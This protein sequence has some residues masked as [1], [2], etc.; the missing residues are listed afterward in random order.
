[1]RLNVFIAQAS[2]LSRRAADRAIEAGRVSINGAPPTLGQQVALADVVLLD[3]QKLQLQQQ[4]Q[5]VLFHKPVGYVCSRNG[6]GSRTIYELLPKELTILNPIGRLDKDSSGLLLLTNDGQLTQQLSHPR[7]QKIK[8]YH[9]ELDS[10]LQPLHQ[11]MISDYGITLEDG[12]SK[13]QLQGLDGSRR[14]WEVRMHEGRNR[15]IRRTFESLGYKVA[16]LHR[17][18]FGDYHLGDLSPGKYK[19][20]GLS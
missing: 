18:Q 17:V 3:G 13:L 16:K 1:M 4:S 2:D 20:T 19:D 12:V 14:T 9:V 15:Q 6:Q 8:V 7:Y 11:Q 5:T 10:G